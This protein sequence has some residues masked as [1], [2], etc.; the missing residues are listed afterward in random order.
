MGAQ[1]ADRMAVFTLY[2][3]F[4][5]GRGG[6]NHSLYAMSLY[7]KREPLLQVRARWTYF[8]CPD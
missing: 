5:W 2:T 7:T 6:Q 1:N 3:P 4:Q 8:A